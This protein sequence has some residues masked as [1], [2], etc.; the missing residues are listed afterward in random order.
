[1]ETPLSPAVIE[2]L[3]SLSEEQQLELIRLAEKT[4]ASLTREERLRGLA[5]LAGSISKEDADEMMAI[6]DEGCG[7][8]NHDAW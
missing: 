4:K 5:A 2:A 6:I 3:S 8:I 1:M 7:Q